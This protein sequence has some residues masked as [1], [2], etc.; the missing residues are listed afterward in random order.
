M[1]VRVVLTFPDT[2]DAHAMADWL[3]DDVDDGA[4]RDLAATIRAQVPVPPGTSRADRVRAL[5][6]KKPPKGYSLHVPAG[7]P[8]ETEETNHG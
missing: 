3:A 8:P 1:S 7:P 5:R 4:A 6:D 2:E